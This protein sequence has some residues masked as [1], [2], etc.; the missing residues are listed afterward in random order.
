MYISNISIDFEQDHH[1]LS[2]RHFLH[3]TSISEDQRA[4]L[5]LRIKSN[6]NEDPIILSCAIGVRN[7]DRLL[8]GDCQSRAQSFGIWLIVFDFDD[9]VGKDVLN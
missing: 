6:R 2:A 5:T 7:K 9:G 1:L 4:L 8:S 3:I